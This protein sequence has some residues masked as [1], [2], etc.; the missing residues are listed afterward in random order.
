MLNQNQD[1][2]TRAEVEIEVLTVMEWAEIYHFCELRYNTGD[3]DAQS[4][5]DLIRG[6]I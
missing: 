1:E 6:S 5:P 2:M 3:L 4:V